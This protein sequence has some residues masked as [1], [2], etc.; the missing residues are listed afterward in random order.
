M[1]IID[2]NKEKEIAIEKAIK[3]LKNGGLII[4]PTETCYGLGG[5]ATNPEALKKIMKYKTLRGSKPVSIAVSDMKMA[6]KYVDINEM[7]TNIYNNYL[8]GPITVISKSKGNLQSPVVSAQGGVGVRY[9]DYPFTLELIKQF[10]KPITATS[11]NVSYRSTPYNIEKL[12]KDLPKQSLKLIDTFLD[13]GE[14][15]K[16]SPSTVLD[17]TMN[18]LSTLRQGKI[19]FEN[20][21]KKDTLLEQRITNSADETIEF[22]KQFARKYLSS[23]TPTVVALSGE[24]G[25]GKTQF[26]KG[27]GD[28]LNVKDI[29]NSPTYTIINE[30]SYIH[31]GKQ[32]VLAHMDTWRLE[33]DELDKSGLVEHIENGDIVLIEWADKFYQEINALCDNMNV[34]MYKVII[35][36]ISIDKRSIEIHE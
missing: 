16:N 7:A 10:G 34:R 33:D 29:V 36:Y 30:Y 21:L 3:V 2:I 8:P 15:P 4:Y 19:E 25:A 35:K 14:L 26:A 13:A 12:I 6:K 32:K 5:D 23:D 24:L 20:S 11:A 27:I 28:V 9:P 1:E 31:N 18:Q 22:A 17:T